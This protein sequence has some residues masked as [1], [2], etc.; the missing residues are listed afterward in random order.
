ME[1]LN[2]EYYMRLA[3][4]LAGSTSGQT[5]GNPVVGCVLV[6]DGRIVGM[7]AHLRQGEAHAE[8]LALQ[9]AGD[10]AEGSTAYVT[11]EP[12]SHTGR[13]PPCS[14][15]LIERR[16]KRVVVAAVDQ[17]PRVSGSG[18][19][20]LQEAGIE[21]HVGVLREEADLLNEAFN[22]YIVTGLPWVTLK[23]ASTLDGRIASKTGDSKWITGEASRA[24][25]HLM[26]HQHQG[27]MAGAGTVCADD[28]QL[29]ARLPVPAMQPV[30]IIVDGALRVPPSARALQG[31][32]EQRTIVL[33]TSGSSAARRAELEA[34]GAE[35]IACG[36]GP[37]V[38]LPLALQELGK[39][40]IAS[41]LVEGG[42][43]LAGALL[44]QR[45]IDKMALFYAPKIIG[46]GASA[47]VNFAF[48]G[49]DRMAE[50]IRLERL[51]VETFGDD[52]C[53]IGYPNYH[54]AKEDTACS[55]D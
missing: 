20:R 14:N 29:S 24:Y 38:D 46:G 16:V 3:L 18:I 28:P 7:G 33:T 42:G 47:P 19:R 48:A 26:R 5:G 55:P 51:R 22:K 37:H 50:A 23:L 6:K 27:I 32:A 10:A 8:V 17:N 30:R 4:Q 15:L 52:I 34:L 54:G 49:F 25:V 35:V 2:D 39:R 43:G 45:L 21:V 9:M 31:A 41:I 44:E 1:M 40:N 11:L 36:Y 53:L 13:T 12:C